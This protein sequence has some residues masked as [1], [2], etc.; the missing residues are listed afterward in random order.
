M[1]ERTVTSS[2]KLVWVKNSSSEIKDGQCNPFHIDNKEKRKLPEKKKIWRKGT[3]LETLL[4]QYGL[5]PL[6]QLVIGGQRAQYYTVLQA[7]TT[8]FISVGNIADN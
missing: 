6:S 5:K 4:F 7:D 1:K 8:K 2:A 3:G